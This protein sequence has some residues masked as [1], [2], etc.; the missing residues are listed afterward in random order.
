MPTFKRV[1]VTIQNNLFEFS[2]WT[3]NFNQLFSFEYLVFNAFIK[4]FDIQT[5]MINI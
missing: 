2:T 5:K 1:F 3:N 4:I